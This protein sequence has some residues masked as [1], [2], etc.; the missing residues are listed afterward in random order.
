MSNTQHTPASKE[1]AAIS[2]TL[3]LVILLLVHED[4]LWRWDQLLYDTQF[5]I[6]STPPPED[7]VIVAIDNASL[8][9]LGRWP[10]SRAVH[11]GLV[12]R[13]TAAGVKAIVLDILFAE[14][15]RSDPQGDQELID[16]VAAS[17]RVVLPI[18]IE[19]ISLGGQLVETLPMPSL[20]EVAAALGH[21]HIDLD[22]DG[23]ARRVNLLEGLGTAYWPALSVALLRM[24]EPG[25]WETLPGTRSQANRK[26]SQYII[27]RDHQILIPFSGPPGHF[28]QI[29]FSDVLTG[30]VRSESL[31]DKIAL[32][33]VTATGLGDDLP[34]PVSGRNQPMQGIEINANLIDALRRG[35]AI[36][37]MG[38]HWRMLFSGS[39]LLLTFVFFPRMPP[40]FV[41]LATGSTILA[42]LL[43]SSLLLHGFQLWFPPTAVLIGS[44]LGYPLWS[45]RRLEH[46]MRYFEQELERLNV[47][48]RAI[49]FYGESLQMS[50][51]LEFL[52]SILSFEG[53]VLRD[54]SG[55]T[56]EGGGQL[57]D[58]PEQQ[59]S[60]AGWL[61]ENSALWT[62]IP[63]QQGTWYFGLRKSNPAAFP[64]S[65][66][67]LLKEFVRQF[68][69]TPI[70]EP[71]SAAEHMENQIQQIQSA[72]AEMRTMRG[73]I[74]DTLR[75]M[76]DGLLVINSVGQVVLA[77]NQAERLLGRDTEAGLMEADILTLTRK[78]EIQ[79]G[80][81]WTEALRDVLVGQDMVFMEGRLPQGKELL[82][83]ISPLSV[84]QGN[85]HGMIVLLSDVS[86]LKQ[87]ERKRS[88]A[89]HFLSHDLRSP[90]TS[91]LSLVQMRRQENSPFSPDE[92]TKRMEHY[93]KK[94]LQLAEDFL[95]LARAENAD[96]ANFQETDFVTIAHNAMDEAYT[97]AQ[98]R[99]IRLIRR[100][101]VD[102]AWIKADAG[103]LERALVNLLQNAIRYSHE[104]STVELFLR[105]DEK[106]I[107]CCVEDR[108]Q[109]IPAEDLQKIFDPFHR[110]QD[111]N[112]RKQ[113]GTGLGLA[114]VKVVA[115]KHQ[116]SVDVES[117]L[118]RG[119]RF[120]L[121][122]PCGGSL[123]SKRNLPH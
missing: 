99:R 87:S 79:T 9:E 93:A 89:L 97:E 59:I 83:Q 34:T 116:G 29:P 68:A 3:V 2:I 53:W 69:S 119:S 13:L 104:D 78:L 100:I 102:E 81:S 16:A 108:G 48:P 96:H 26:G 54:Q 21:V 57:P 77:N 43:L 39:L 22:P 65:A 80:I 101:E 46:T 37:V 90:I 5:R 49:H 67:L 6:W 106:E 85:F 84:E 95:Q 62:S 12:K 118:G 47:E 50:R 105:G 41:L 66:R 113:S 120:C 33:G 112:L 55:Q 107:Q 18:V 42:T 82:I 115:L 94:A 45:W 38:I 15:D 92:I 14:E 121:K 111:S 117:R 88:E 75:Q 32:V 114:L 25:G 51:G 24:I 17:G 74:S 4:W 23:I 56:I 86:L 40:K 31:R 7:I 98:S 122:I 27:V 10:W 35:V 30:R 76:V 110:V 36:E 52:R 20:A 28:P 64:E 71:R 70:S 103:M 1:W 58:D 60:D 91:L 11:A 123:G 72:I 109:G 44:I 61:Q 73:L 8:S 19:Q 63:W